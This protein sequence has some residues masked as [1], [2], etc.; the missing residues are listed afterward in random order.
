MC[1][2]RMSI[3]ILGSVCSRDGGAN[4][5]SAGV[6]RATLL[7]LGCQAFCKVLIRTH[8]SIWSNSRLIR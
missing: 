2:Q 6:Q 8:Q 7:V 3:C 5:L 4:V 1:T